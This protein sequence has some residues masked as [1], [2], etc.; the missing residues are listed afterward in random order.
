[1]SVYK[2]RAHAVQVRDRNEVFAAMPACKRGDRSVAEQSN[3]FTVRRG[4]DRRR[5]F[6]PSD[7]RSKRPI[8][9]ESDRQAEQKHAAADLHLGGF[10]QLDDDHN[11]A[12]TKTS[13]IENWPCWR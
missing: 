1:M 3:G 8:G 6:V 12:T 13:S 2:S 10:A 5:R 9:H 7:A 4:A 11:T